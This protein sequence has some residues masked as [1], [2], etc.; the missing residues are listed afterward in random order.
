ME[1][2]KPTKTNQI[3]CETSDQCRRLCLFVEVLGG[4][5]FGGWGD[6]LFGPACEVNENKDQQ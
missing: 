4:F 3:L 2:D 6:K 5:F 1:K